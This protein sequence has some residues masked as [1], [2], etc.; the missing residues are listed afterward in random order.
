MQ[1]PSSSR[2]LTVS[3]GSTF[4]QIG[5]KTW[6]VEQ[7]SQLGIAAPTPVQVHCISKVLEVCVYTLCMLQFMLSCVTQGRDVLGCAKTGTGKTLVFALPILQTLADDPYG[8]YALVLTPTRELAFQIAEQ[9]KA[10]G[11]P[12]GLKVGVS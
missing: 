4:Q 3:T 11:R 1:S 9:F 12:L 5:I 7:L 6:L 2:V 10:L 8:I